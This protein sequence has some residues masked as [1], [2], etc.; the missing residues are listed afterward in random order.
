M[1]LIDF[2]RRVYLHPETDLRDSTPQKVMFNSDY[3][4]HNSL[5]HHVC[6]I[7]MWAHIEASKHFVQCGLLIFLII[8]EGAVYKY[9]SRN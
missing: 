1:L 7:I 3:N 5:Y 6:M 2:C 8:Y 9:V 4:R